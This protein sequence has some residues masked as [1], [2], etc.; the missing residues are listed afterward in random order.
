M[1]VVL[2]AIASLLL[3]PILVAEEDDDPPN[4]AQEF[5][6]ASFDHGG[7]T[8]PYRLLR[9]KPVDAK[10]KYPLV[11][12]LHGAGERGT[13]NHQ[14][15]ELVAVDFAAPAVREKFPCFVIAPQCG[16]NQQWV[17][18]PWNQSTSHTMPK[19]PS[20]SM[21][22]TIALM[23]KLTKELP[24]DAQRIHVIGVSMGGYGAW[25]ILARKPDWFAGGVLL[26]GGADVASAPLI[27]HIPQWI[28]HGDSDDI[29]PTN[30][31]RIMVKALMAAGGTPTYTEVAG[32]G[33]FVWNP[34]M[35]NPELI[36]WMFAQKKAATDN[37][38]VKKK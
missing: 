17:D 22:L 31:S 13:D 23:E 28:W 16:V 30:R 2:I 21:G 26:C 32:E 29:V 15:L 12:F 35:S 3:C 8:L 4:S 18:T 37:P 34:A 25:D 5:E 9:P 36:P 38:A 33:H 20:T 24:V 19:E 14:H 10:V 27:K 11:L 1:N 7:K 6:K